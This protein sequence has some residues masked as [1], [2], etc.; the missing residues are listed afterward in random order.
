MKT[1]SGLGETTPQSA[2]SRAQG[3]V[4]VERAGHLCFLLAGYILG[5]GGLKHGPLQ[6]KLFLARWTGSDSLH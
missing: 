3:R 2:G 4:F 1:Q 6:R 5:G